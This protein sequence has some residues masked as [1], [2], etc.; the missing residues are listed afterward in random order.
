ML[1]YNACGESA[2][3][4]NLFYRSRECFCKSI[5][6]FYELLGG[7]NA[8]YG[9]VRAQLL[10]QDHL[11][12]IGTVFALFQEDRRH[13]MLEPEPQLPS[14]DQST[15]LTNGR[16]GRGLGGSPGCGIGRCQSGLYG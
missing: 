13:V 10:S 7:A 11:P 12:S 16:G 1:K 9:T 4:V 8:E 3:Y 15:L 6:R 5:D 2:N 14:Q